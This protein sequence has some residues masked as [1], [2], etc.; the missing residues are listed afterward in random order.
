MRLNAFCAALV[1]PMPASSEPTMPIA[2]AD[3]AAFE[4]VQFE[5]VAED[6]ELPERA[7]HDFFLV[8]WMPCRHEAEDRHEHEQ[9]REDRDE[10][11]VGDQ[12]GQLP[13]LVVV[14]FFTT[15]ARKPSRGL[16]CWRRSSA[17]RVSVMPIRRARA[18]L[19]RGNRP[20]RAAIGRGVCRRSRAT[21]SRV[22]P[23]SAGKTSCGRR[24]AGAARGLRAGS[25]GGGC[26]R[27]LR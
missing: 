4:R 10:G 27:G 3:A 6:R 1:M 14:N 13:G 25:G 9:Q 2:S 7:V 23:M 21:C 17:W 16:C 20:A 5:L 8:A 12:R 19:R 26:D 22:Y 18:G 24:I 11:V 15:A